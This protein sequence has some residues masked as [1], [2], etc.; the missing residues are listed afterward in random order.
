MKDECF[1]GDG[2]TVQIVNMMRGGGKHRNKKNRADKKPTASPK[3]SE[4]M[5]GQHEDDEEK[6]I[7]DK[8]LL[9]REKAEDEV[10]RYFG[11]TE[12]SRR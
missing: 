8:S 5:R 7:Q 10:I 9:S 12:G 4:P 3:N 2:C 1:V 11:K 6:I